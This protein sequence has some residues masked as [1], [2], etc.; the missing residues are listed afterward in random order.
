[1][2]LKLNIS[3]TVTNIQPYSD[4]ENLVIGEYTNSIGE[5]IIIAFTVGKRF[6]IMRKALLDGIFQK[7][8][9]VNY[10]TYVISGI[11]KNKQIHPNPFPCQL[12]YTK[13]NGI[14]IQYFS[15]EEDVPS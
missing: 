14:E 5:L 7:D 9:G 13:N 4:D 2:E 6:I 1:M 10:V 12:Q 15:S 8:F 11:L 3:I